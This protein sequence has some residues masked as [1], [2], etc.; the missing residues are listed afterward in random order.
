MR[1]VLP[2]LLSGGGVRDRVRHVEGRRDKSRNRKVLGQ[3]ENDV[4]VERCWKGKAAKGKALYMVQDGV[5]RL[6][7]YGR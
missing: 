2:T 6:E 5:L 3:A 7:K 4:E 1:G